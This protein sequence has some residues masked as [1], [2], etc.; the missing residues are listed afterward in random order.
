MTRGEA[1]KVKQS[2]LSSSAKKKSSSSRDSDAE[3]AA[4]TD[5]AEV[6]LAELFHVLKVA[7]D[8]QY[9]PKR[10]AA[11]EASLQRDASCALL[12]PAAAKEPCKR[13]L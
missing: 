10:A 2:S 6:E 5:R 12:R 1:K 13:T 4:E 9:G 8:K 11:L 3:T 7:K